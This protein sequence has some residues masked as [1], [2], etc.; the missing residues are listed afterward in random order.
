MTVYL[1]ITV[2]LIGFLVYCCIWDS[3]GGG[4]DSF[5][6]VMCRLVWKHVRLALTLGLGFIFAVVAV[7]SILGEAGA[8]SKSMTIYGKGPELE[9]YRS[10]SGQVWHGV[11]SLLAPFALLVCILSSSVRDFY[12]AHMTPC[13]LALFGLYLVWLWFTVRAIVRHEFPNDD[14]RT[15]A[16]RSFGAIGTWAVVVSAS[17]WSVHRLLASMWS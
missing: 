2:L 6:V 9:K 11:A 7:M 16:L 8:Y 4:T 17:T 1:L 14:K 5:W 15:W 12:L 13:N 10:F 3:H